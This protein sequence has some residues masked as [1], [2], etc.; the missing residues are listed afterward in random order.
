MSLNN[1]PEVPVEPLREAF[2]RSG[3]TKGELAR[4]LG[5]MK[6]NVDQVNR[7]LGYRPDSDSR[8]KLRP[9]PRQQTSYAIALTVCEVL[10]V[11]PVDV[12]V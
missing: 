10:G 6:P 9:R 5:M 2:E 7:L 12:G 11:D 3:L 1:R 8:G 4:R